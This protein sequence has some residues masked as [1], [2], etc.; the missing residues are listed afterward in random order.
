MA[1]YN[2]ENYLLKDGV[3][4]RGWR[5]NYPK[6]ERSKTALRAVIAAVNP[7]VLAVQEMGTAPFLR[8]LQRDLRSDG[9][10]YPYV[11]LLAAQDEVRHLAV[12]SRIPVAEVHEHTEMTFPYFGERE[13][14]KRGLLEVVFQ[15]KGERW[16]LFVVHLKS[17]WTEHPDDPQAEARR[18][19]EATAARNRILERHDPEAGAL[20]LIAG[21]FNDTRDTAPLRRFLRKGPVQISEM[22][23]TGDSRGHSWTHYW[24]RQDLYSRVDFLLVSPAMKGNVV[25]GEGYIYDHSGY[26]EASDH[27]LVWADFRFGEKD[28]EKEGNG[29]LGP[30]LVKLLRE[31]SE[32]EL[33]DAVP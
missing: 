1:T 30:R 26:E 4:E 8:E 32:G 2:L 24:E 16:S 12:L 7:D 28:R 6:T 10:D 9:L 3:T 13:P 14:I 23:P 11:C 31:F 33:I 27:R 18:T 29:K 21:D 25:E 5:P 15:T 22:I 20:F 17:K 19:G